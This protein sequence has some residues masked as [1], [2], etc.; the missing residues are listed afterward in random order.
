MDAGI[1]TL[2][3]DNLLSIDGGKVHWQ[4]QRIVSKGKVRDEVVWKRAVY[5]KYNRLINARQTEGSV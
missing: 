3:K 5:H 1:G 2:F 4:I